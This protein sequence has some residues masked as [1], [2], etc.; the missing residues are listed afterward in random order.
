MWNK[1]RPSLKTSAQTLGLLAGS[2][3]I[4][5]VLLCSNG[6]LEHRARLTPQ[7]GPA[8]VCGVEVNRAPCLQPT[9]STSFSLQC[10]GEG[11]KGAP[12]AREVSPD[13]FCCDSEVDRCATVASSS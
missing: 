1:G 13:W 7:P 9:S 2:V 11:K 10:A 8:A 6:W 5:D 12:Q 4:L 3:A